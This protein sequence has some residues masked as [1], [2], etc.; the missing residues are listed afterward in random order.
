MYP[1]GLKIKPIGLI[2][3]NIADALDGF[4]IE[5]KGS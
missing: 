1:E 2:R 5:E 3:A 4:S